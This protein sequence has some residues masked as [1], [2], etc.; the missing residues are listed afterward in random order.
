MWPCGFSPE[1]CEEM[2]CGWGPGGRTRADPRCNLKKSGKPTGEQRHTKHPNQNVKF[3][4]KERLGGL[5]ASF[6]N[7]SRYLEN[8]AS[9]LWPQQIDCEELQV[10]F[11]RAPESLFQ[12]LKKV[13]ILTTDV[14]NK[15]LSG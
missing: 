9:L 14:Y 10:L 15:V 12:N 13:I 6:Q 4:G 2:E 7:S 5:T 1:A 8:T 3:E 11:N